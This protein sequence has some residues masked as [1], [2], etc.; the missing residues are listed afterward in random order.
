MTT[1]MVQPTASFT[2]E[3]D[4]NPDMYPSFLFDFNDDEGWTVTGIT[5]L[6]DLEQCL[7]D[8]PEDEMTK[9]LEV[10]PFKPKNGV[11]TVIPAHTKVRIVLNPDDMTFEVK[12]DEEY[13]AD[14]D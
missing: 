14:T 12:T 3:M 6:D 10:G 13:A 9:L 8:V 7:S 5:T 11:E 4:L 2:M 1:N